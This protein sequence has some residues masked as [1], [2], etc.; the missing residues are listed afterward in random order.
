METFAIKAEQILLLGDDGKYDEAYKK[1]L[2]ITLDG[3][4]LTYRDYEAIAAKGE[5]G[6][7]TLN[8]LLSDYRRKVQYA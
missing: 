7:T 2:A 8:K 5:E 6:V 4:R 3:Y 1:I